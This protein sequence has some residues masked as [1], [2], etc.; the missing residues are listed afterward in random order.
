VVNPAKSTAL[1]VLM[2]VLICVVDE[3][4]EL[5]PF[6]Q[7]LQPICKRKCPVG[8]ANAV[9]CLKQRTKKKPIEELAAKAERF[10]AEASYRGYVPASSVGTTKLDAL[11][12]QVLAHPSWHGVIKFWYNTANYGFAE[13]H[14]LVD[15]K[16]DILLCPGRRLHPTTDIP[17]PLSSV[18]NQ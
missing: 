17:R 4:S 13:R 7:N 18:F 9:A 2:A 8:E 12:D 14:G 11:R 15:I 10:T 3:L 1:D 16:G 5:D 6:G